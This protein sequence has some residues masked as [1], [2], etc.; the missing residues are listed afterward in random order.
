[1]PKDESPNNLARVPHP[2][3]CAL[4]GKVWPY[5]AKLHDEDGNQWLSFAIYVRM[6][7]NKQMTV[8][9]NWKGFS[10]VPEKKALVICQGV[11][12][13]RVDKDGSPFLVLR[14]YDSK[15]VRKAYCTA[16]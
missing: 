3:G 11:P 7:E 10:W 9:V 13:L 16:T 2:T 8:F 15:G 12:I 4:W 5:G 14:C 1:M 6:P